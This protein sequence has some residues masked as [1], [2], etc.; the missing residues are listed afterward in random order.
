MLIYGKTI[1]IS[2]AAC[3]K[4]KDFIQTMDLRCVYRSFRHC[5]QCE[6]SLGR[7]KNK[8]KRLINLAFLKYYNMDE[9]GKISHLH[10]QCLSEESGVRVFMSCHI[11]DVTAVNFN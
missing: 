7:V 2:N 3:P 8:K 1:V 4:T 9:N 11:T 10:K 6:H 5:R